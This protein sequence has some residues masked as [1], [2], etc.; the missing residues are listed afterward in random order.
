MVAMSL[1]FLVCK[2]EW[3]AP[4]IRGGPRLDEHVLPS[5]WA[6]V[7]PGRALGVWVGQSHPPT[8]QG[9]CRVGSR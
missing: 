1:G 5:A 3:G 7:D 6:R 9:Q 4:P 8:T 2:M